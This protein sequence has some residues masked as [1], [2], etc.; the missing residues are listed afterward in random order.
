MSIFDSV[1][2]FVSSRLFFDACSTMRLDLVALCG[3]SA[4][5]KFRSAVVGV[6]DDTSA[7]CTAERGGSTSRV[8]T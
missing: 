4:V 7:L 1:I 6:Y 2:R 5:P 8:V 3:S